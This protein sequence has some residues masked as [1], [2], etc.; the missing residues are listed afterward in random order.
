MAMKSFLNIHSSK[1]VLKY[2]KDAAVN[3]NFKNDEPVDGGNHSKIFQFFVL[4]CF[5]SLAR[6]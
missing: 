5:K 2:S 3:A 6:L 4:F 1:N